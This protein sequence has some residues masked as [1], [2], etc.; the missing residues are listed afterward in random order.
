MPASSVTTPRPQL[1][2]PINAQTGT[3]YAIVAADL[4]K[5]VTFKNAAAIA[6]TLGNAFPTSWFCRLKNLGAGVV[7]L[8]ITGATLEGAT[9]IV[10]PP[11]AAALIVYDGTNYE[12]LEPGS[13]NG[14]TGL[15][16]TIETQNAQM[17]GYSVS[18]TGS[19]CV[20]VANEVD[21]FLIQILAPQLIRKVGFRISTG[22]A[23]STF[24]AGMA[25]VNGGKIFSTGAQS[26]ATTNQQ[27]DVNLGT[28]YLLMPGVYRIVWTSSANTVTLYPSSSMNIGS[29]F[30]SPW[31]QNS[32]KQFKCSTAAS[33]GD[34]PASLGTFAQSALAITT[35]IPAILFET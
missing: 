35:A 21:G 7:T 24:A 27:Y 31:N 15:P 9:V 17:Q 26:S 23:A 25:D 5:L 30:T 34:I 1:S 13:I 6:V 19:A 33:G 8:T 28:S 22:V 11:G 32:V 12:L 3:S 4:G 29:S 14:G 20:A 10:F 18:G 2:I 16:A